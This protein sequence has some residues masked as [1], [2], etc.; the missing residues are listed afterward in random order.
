[1]SSLKF[2][3]QIYHILITKNAASPSVSPI[4]PIT[5]CIPIY[6][7]IAVSVHTLQKLL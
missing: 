1:M 5:T 2:P 4:Q 3:N 7:A 6:T